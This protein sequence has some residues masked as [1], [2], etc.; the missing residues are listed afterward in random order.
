MTVT[1]YQEFEIGGHQDLIETHE[2]G[3]Q[4]IRKIKWPA[5]TNVKKE[6]I[7]EDSVMVA[8]KPYFEAGWEITASTETVQSRSSEYILRIFLRKEE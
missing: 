7:H 5:P 2:D 1:I 8:L 3:T 4:T 6:I